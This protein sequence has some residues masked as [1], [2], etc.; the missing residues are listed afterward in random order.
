METKTIYINDN[1]YKVLIAATQEEQE[2]GLMDVEEMDADEGMLFPQSGAP[3][4]VS[5]WL[6]NTDIPLDIIFISEEDEV[7]KVI[8]GMPNSD[9]S[10][11]CKAPGEHYIKAVVELNQNSGVKK[12]DDVEFEA[13]EEHPELEPNKMYIIG[14]D[15]T[16]QAE[17]SGGERIFSR[18]STRGI[19][20][21]AKRAYL[22]KTD[23]AYK[24]LG[25]YV[26]NELT[27]QDERKP[28]YVNSRK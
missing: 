2:R 23:A 20:K 13:F 18:I 6:H 26:F 9:D 3:K 1:A 16:V 15:G 5:F 24:A 28:E 17:L 22:L 25:R 11:I 4:E 19:L 21:R 7:I 8:K 14:S 27:A 10:L 12:G